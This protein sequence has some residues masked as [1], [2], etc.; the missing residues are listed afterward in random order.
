MWKHVVKEHEGNN[1]DVKFDFV[2]TGKF[3]KPTERQINEAYKIKRNKGK[4]NLNSKK[5]YNGQSL[6]RV[7][8]EDTEST[9]SDGDDLVVPRLRSNTV[10]ISNEGISS[11][12]DNCGTIFHNK[13]EFN[14][15]KYEHSCIPTYKCNQ[16]DEAF[17]TTQQ[18]TFHK[19]EVHRKEKTKCERNEDIYRTK[20]SEKT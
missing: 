15:H 7:V 19:K 11:T 14:S 16:C 6:K 4:T 5:E 2:V 17:Q 9:K 1:D 10:M 13:Q 3:M 8:I 20:D 12:C 18:L